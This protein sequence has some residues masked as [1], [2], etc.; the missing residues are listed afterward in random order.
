[1][2]SESQTLS[3]NQYAPNSIAEEKTYTAQVAKSKRQPVFNEASSLCVLLNMQTETVRL[4]RSELVSSRS[5]I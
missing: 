2:P 4:H 1:M 5:L 3:R